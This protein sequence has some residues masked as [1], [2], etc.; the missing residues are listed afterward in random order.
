MRY[1]YADIRSK[2]PEDP[3]WFDEYAIPRY[4]IFEPDSCA[5]IYAEE[6]VLAEVTCQ[7]CGHVF[8]VAFSQGR[9]RRFKRDNRTLAMDIQEKQLHYGDPPNVGCC[10]AGPTMNSEPR[11]V[12]EYWSRHDSRYLNEGIVQDVKAYFQW[13][14][15]P[16]LEIDIEPEWVAMP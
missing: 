14:R 12:I 9:M 7:G 1:D 5:D 8:K 13:V 16:S 4:C 10:I 11:R 6:A 15:N 2:I 3:H